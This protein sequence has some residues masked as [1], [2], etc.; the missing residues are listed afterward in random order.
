M[1]IPFIAWAVYGILRLIGP[2]LRFE[3]V[4]KKNAVNR[5]ETGQASIGA[6]WHRCIIPTLWYYRHDGIVVMITMNFDG[7]WTSRVIEKLGYRVAQGS[8]SRGGMTALNAMAR[9]V[10]A[11]WDVAFTPDGPRGPR[12]VAKPGPV[13][14]ARRTGKPITVFHIGLK[15]A[16]TF[17]KSWD[18]LRLPHLFSRAVLVMAPPIY[19]AA[20]GDSEEMQKKIAEMQAALERVRDV[21]ESWFQLSETE[22][23]HLREEWNK[24]RAGDS[25]RTISYESR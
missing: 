1:Q 4:G 6:F 3:F 14:L 8:S 5:R 22:R 2:T 24:E 10:E 17:K 12:Y 20:D 23:Q 9:E 15:S 19:V 7:L 21:A 25:P 11:G 16:H 13:M 18:N